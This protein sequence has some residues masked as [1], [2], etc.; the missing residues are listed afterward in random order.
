MNAFLAGCLAITFFGLGYLVKH[1]EF[2]IN[3]S[4]NMEDEE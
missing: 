2:K 1:C 4:I 3:V